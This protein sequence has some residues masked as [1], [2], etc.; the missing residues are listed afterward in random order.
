MRPAHVYANLSDEQYHRLVSALHCQGRVATRT[1]MVL[2]S[3]SGMTAAEIGVL[4]RYDP[5]T[6]RRWIARHDVDGAAGL[7]D[8]PRCGRPRIGGARLSDRIR[9]PL[10]APK[11]WT[12]PRVLRALGRP[13][14][15]LRTCY[16][17]IREHARWRRPR[18]IAKGDPDR[19]VIRQRI[20]ATI[21]ALPT[22]SVVPAADETH[23][24]LLARIRA[25][26]ALAGARQKVPAPGGNQ[27]RGLFGAVNLATGVFHYR[28][29][30][31]AVSAA[32]CQF[33]DH[34]LS[35][36]PVAPMVVVTCG[37]ASIH[38]SGITACLLA[39]H[40]RL[41]LLEGAR[42]C[43]QANPTER[44]WA[45][46]KHQIA[47]T[48]PAT[49]ADRLRQ[50][51]VFFRYRTPEQNLITAAPGRTP[52]LPDSYRQNFRQVA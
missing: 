39:A 35:A 42:Y 27:R 28:I 37:N 33:L 24:D 11:A 38:H 1:V 50:V 8:R 21:A 46:L 14:I 52:W 12:T 34:L 29:A 15:S 36:Y 22:G 30:R 7:A 2:L 41:L 26:W 19:E 20:R 48:A 45:A 9:T 47:N 31:R 51:H 40:P 13:A 43:P 23:L 6:V 16:R 3:A 5:A 44:V 17:R 10:A 18:L 25:C 32:F 49:M 4:L